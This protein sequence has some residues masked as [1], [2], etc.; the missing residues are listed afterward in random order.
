MFTG[1]IQELGSVI[2]LEQ[3]STGARLTVRCQEVLADA[4]IGASIA[5]NGACLTA[6]Q[7][8]AGAFS[9]DLAPETL[10]RTNLGDL[11]RGA[12]VNLE[13]SL[14]ANAGSTDILFWAMWIALRSCFR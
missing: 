4:K 11:E 3:N 9:A 14:A 8:A 5:V 2:S 1:I 12:A 6:V 10:K 7:I 13:R